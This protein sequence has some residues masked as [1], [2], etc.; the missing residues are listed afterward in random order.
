[1]VARVL[2][3][4][5]AGV[6]LLTERWRRR[7]PVVVAGVPT[8]RPSHAV[9]ILSAVLAEVQRAEDALWSVLALTIDGAT[10]DALAQFGALLGTPNPGLFDTKYRVLLHAA[11]AAI[12]SS[13]TG[14]E[15]VAILATLGGSVR[16][17]LAES[18][19]ASLVVEPVAAPSIP[20]E[21]L[22]SVLRR[23]VAGG[24]RLLVV[25]VPTGDTFAFSDTDETV[26]DTDR[27]LSDVSGLPGGQ[28]VGVIE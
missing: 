10:D 25:D 8:T 26:T 18:F 7:V 14:P 5:D 20:A 3:H 27:G 28:L 12:H 16:L 9:T 4:V 22:L 24:V 15:I 13:G 19:P 1:M 23:A 21:A 2:D 11:A 6:A 17:A